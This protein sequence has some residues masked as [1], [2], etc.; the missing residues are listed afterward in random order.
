M[1]GQLIENVALR[2]TADDEITVD[3]QNLPETKQPRVWLLHKPT[4]FITS[5]KDGIKRPL[6]FDLLPKNF[7][8]VHVIGRLDLNS[9][10]LLLL[11]NHAPLK[12]AMELP[13]TQ[14]KRRY[15]VRVFGTVTEANLNRLRGG[16]TVENTRYAPMEVEQE[17]H[18][19]EGK[20]SWLR[21]TLTE[22]KNREIRKSCA[23]IGLQVNRLIRTEY[24]MFS[25]DDLPRAQYTEADAAS[26]AAQLKKVGDG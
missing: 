12:R 10:G 25:L 3:G 4:G 2:V 6:V 16:I 8:Y 9:E 26:V 11:T 14:I 18:D 5:R 20:N 1:N 17:P 7:P 21:F 23:A 13:K 22:G 15:R 19:G 24:G